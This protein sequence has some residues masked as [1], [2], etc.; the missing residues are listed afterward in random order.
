MFEEIVFTNNPT[1]G[2][3]R[4]IR[5]LKD[6][7]MTKFIGAFADEIGV[8]TN[9]NKKFDIED[10][11]VFLMAAHPDEFMEFSNSEENIEL[12]S[13][14]SLATNKIWNIEELDTYSFDEVDSLYEKSL[15]VLGG[16]VTRFFKKSRLNIQQEIPKKTKKLPT[17]KKS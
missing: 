13:V 5:G 4:K 6:A 7:N 14:I 15:E 11:L 16:D 17:K 1:H 8:L 12:L 9:D 2:V 3:V 10:A